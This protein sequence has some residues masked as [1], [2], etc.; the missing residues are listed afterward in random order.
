MQICIFAKISS[1]KSGANRRD[2]EKNNALETFG[3]SET[4]N[5]WFESKKK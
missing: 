4:L 2:K 3:S 5:P 1:E